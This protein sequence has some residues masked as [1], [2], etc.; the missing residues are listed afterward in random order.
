MTPRVRPWTGPA[1]E[2]VPAPTPWVM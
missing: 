2:T 1:F